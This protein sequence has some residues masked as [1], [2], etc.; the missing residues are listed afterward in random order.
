[1]KPGVY[2]E[3]TIPSY[4][5]ARPTTDVVLAGRQQ[6]TIQ[7]WAQRERFFL[8]VSKLV[9]KEA[10]DGDPDAAARRLAALVGIPLLAP[11]EDAEALAST[12]MREV[13]LPPKAES[14]ALHVAIAALNGMEYFLTWNCAHIANAVFRPKMEVVCEEFGV[15]CPTICTPEELL[16]ETVPE[17]NPYD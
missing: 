17:V 11:S 10:G 5:T 13:G 2:I 16:L 12:L 9:L 8:Y 15:R 1:M 14:D 6:L 7:W 4:L 3:T